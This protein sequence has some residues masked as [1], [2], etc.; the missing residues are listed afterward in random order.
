MYIDICC[1]LIVAYACVCV[2]HN[3]DQFRACVPSLLLRHSGSVISSYGFFVV[4]GAAAVLNSSS[5]Y[6]NT[7]ARRCI[8]LYAIVHGTRVVF[9]CKILWL[10]FH[11]TTTTCV[12]LFRRMPTQP[13]PENEIHTRGRS[14]TTTTTRKTTH[15]AHVSFV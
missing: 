13:H 6:T 12:G 3:D 15:M 8:A 9:R 1:E 5:T 10:V 4:R 11:N 2:W 7:H 14:W